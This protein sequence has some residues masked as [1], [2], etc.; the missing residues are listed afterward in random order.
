MIN[1]ARIECEAKGRGRYKIVRDVESSILE[2]ATKLVNFYR[3]T[4]WSA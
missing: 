1:E 4:T 2:G 3:T